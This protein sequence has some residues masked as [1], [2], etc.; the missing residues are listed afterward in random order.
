[1]TKIL[2][3]SGALQE[4]TA[5]TVADF[6]FEGS[7]RLIG[8]G[9]SKQGGSL[10]RVLKRDGF[11]G[12]VGTLY[13]WHPA[14]GAPVR[15]YLVA[16]LGPRKQYRLETLRRACAAVARKLRAYPDRHL[17]L[18][19]AAGPGGAADA[20]EMA[21]AGVEGVL[22]GNYQFTKYRTCIP[23]PFL[24]LETIHIIAPGGR[25]SQVEKGIREGKLAAEAT[26]FARDLVSE[27]AG[28]LNP[29]RMVAIAKKV[30]KENGLA[31]EVLEGARLRKLGMGGLLGVGQGSSEPP[32]L[33]LLTYRPRGR[34]ARKRVGIVGKGITFD[35]G[36]LSLKNADSMETMKC[37]MAGAA[38]VLAV[39]RALPSLAPPVEVV[40][41]LA[42]AEN[43]P[44]G[45]AIRPG[46]ILKMHSGL[47]VEVRNTDAEGR[48][49]LGD[50]LSYL[51]KQSVDE[52]INLA[53]LTGACVVALGPLCAG[54][55]GN[56]QTLIN[57]VLKSADRSGEM[58]WQLPLFEDYLYQV[59]SDVADIRNAGNRWGGAITAGL[60]L[61]K[62]VQDS[63]PWAHIDIAG[64]AF[65]DDDTYHT[66]KGATGA[67]VRTLLRLLSDGNR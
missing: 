2:F 9:S 41:V 37:D 3:Q 54:V 52:M 50:A 19:L 22:L 49:I 40:G 11:S 57:R 28:F 67:G 66:P 64:P 61:K 32:Y 63:I 42:L 60:F 26:N 53:T 33:V 14:G 46:D 62:F 18:P 59:E 13:Q 20:A 17:A 45:K 8:L 38:C 10:S 5:D 51:A 55:M 6:V 29:S 27:P 39:M 44:G 21:R 56:N 47:T 30:A 58:M 25:K 31:C 36:G 15:R 35:S 7:S 65:L 34:K 24:S 43:M 48:L 1:M 16:G 12:K 4:A 23:K